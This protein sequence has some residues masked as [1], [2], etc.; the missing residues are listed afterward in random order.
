MADRTGVPVMF[1]GN[2]SVLLKARD[3]HKAAEI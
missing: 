3:S 1:R 2:A